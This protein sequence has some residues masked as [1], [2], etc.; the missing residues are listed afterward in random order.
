M[1]QVFVLQHA[2][3]E[4]LSII[5]DALSDA[6]T[7]ALTIRGDL[8]EVIPS[9]L[10]GAAGL[11]VMGGP[12]GVYEHDRYPFLADEVRLI[13]SALRADVPVLGVCLGSQLLASALGAKVYKG[14][15]KEIGWHPVYLDNAASGDGL[16]NGLPNRFEGF[17]WHG[18]IF[19][20]PEGAVKIARSDITP[21]QA[22]RYRNAA[23]ILFHMEVT[24]A[25]IT[26]M[27]HAFP[28]ELAEANVS[29]AAIAAESERHLQPL[30]AIGRQVFARWAALA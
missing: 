19:D 7:G 23:G 21:L 27:I 30:Q 4:G 22:F 26:G 2:E 24:E 14:T 10:N 18:D 15:R 11:I 12:M 9:G 20:L 13:Q 28:D 5:G 6:G 16:F 3:C 1:K 17:H 25:S 29:G 8:G